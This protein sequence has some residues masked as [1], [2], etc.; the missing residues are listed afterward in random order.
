[1]YILSPLD[2]IQRE[3]RNCI[4]EQYMLTGGKNMCFTGSGKLIPKDNQPQRGSYNN[5]GYFGQHGCGG[6]YG[7]GQVC[8]GQRGRG[9][10]GGIRDRPQHGTTQEQN[11]GQT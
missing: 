6:G 8:G 1:M 2:L 3:W 5:H 7:R 4:L 9:Q 10:G 11:I